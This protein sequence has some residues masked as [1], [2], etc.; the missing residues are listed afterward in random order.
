MCVGPPE[1]VVLHANFGELVCGLSKGLFRGD[2]GDG[3][4]L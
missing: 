1:S 3:G 2:D 4:R